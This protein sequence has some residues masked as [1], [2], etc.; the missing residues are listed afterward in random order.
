MPSLTYNI[1]SK[2][3][4]DNLVNALD[5]IRC[6]QEFAQLTDARYPGIR[7]NQIGTLSSTYTRLKQA[8]SDRYFSPIPQIEI[9]VFNKDL[10]NH[11]PTILVGGIIYCEK[12]IVNHSSFSLCITFSSNTSVTPNN[13]ALINTDSCCLV[14]FGNLK[15][16]VRRFHFDHQPGENQRPATHIQFGGNFPTTDIN[17][18]NLHYCLHNSLDNPRIP[19][20]P[21]DLVLLLDMA[22]RDFKTPLASFAKESGWKSLVQ[23][24]QRI[25]W[26]DYFNWFNSTVINKTDCLFHDILYS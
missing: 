19:Y 4:K 8:P 7:P 6:N 11:N 15:R 9:P 17:T 13:G 2:Q 10:K 26:S 1:N 5:F 14:H 24:S 3:V 22:I 18:T 16:I 25:W 23:K 12:G 21:M 20:F